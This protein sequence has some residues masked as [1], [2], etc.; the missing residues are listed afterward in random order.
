MANATIACFVTVVEP[1][2]MNFNHR[3]H[4]GTMGLRWLCVLCGSNFVSCQGD[5]IDFYQH[6]FRETRDF[7]C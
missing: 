3:G 5:Y 2:K 4:G 7:D 1:S 6:V